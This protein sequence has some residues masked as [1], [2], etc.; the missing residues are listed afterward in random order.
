MVSVFFTA[1][2]THDRHRNK[3]NV[4]F[5]FLY[6]KYKSEK[7]NYIKNTLCTWKIKNREKFSRIFYFFRRPPIAE[8]RAAGSEMGSRQLGD[9]KKKVLSFLFRASSDGLC[10]RC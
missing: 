5:M 4:H 1:M 7:K 10:V 6:T 9:D 2:L 3:K 8:D